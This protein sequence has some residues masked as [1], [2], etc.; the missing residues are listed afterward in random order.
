MGLAAPS[1]VENRSFSAKLINLS[2]FIL[3]SKKV[4]K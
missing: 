3:F 4:K 2:K 1:S